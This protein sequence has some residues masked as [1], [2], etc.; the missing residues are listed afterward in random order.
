MRRQALGRHSDWLLELAE[1][2][3]EETWLQVDE[4]DDEEFEPEPWHELYFQAFDALR[5]DRFFGA[6]GGES[7]ITYIASSKYA[8][9]L[10]LTGDDRRRF[11]LFLN[12]LDGEHLEAVK[13]NEKEQQENR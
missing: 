8:D 7:P 4:P 3:P 13:R 10:G 11:F 5:F 12:V 1:A 6:F 2:F 9:D